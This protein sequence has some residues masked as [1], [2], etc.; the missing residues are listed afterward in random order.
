MI[1]TPKGCLGKPLTHPSF[2]LITGLH[3]VLNKEVEVILDLVRTKVAAAH[4]KIAVLV[5]FILITGFFVSIPV[6][7]HAA[8]CTSPTTTTVG[9]DTVV[10]FTAVESCDWT[11]PAGV[12][13]VWAVVVGGGGASGAGVSNQWWGA[14]GGGGQVTSQTISV[15]SGNTISLSVGAGGATGDGSASSFGSLTANGGKTPTNSTAVGG[16]SGSGMNG[17]SGGAGTTGNGGGGAW[18]A[19][20][21]INPGDGIS[22]SITGATVEYGGGGNGYNGGTTTGTARSGAGSLGVAALA[23]RGGGG[24]LLN[25]A[26]LRGAG[27]SGVVIIRY[28]T[29]GECSPTSA[30]VGTD[31]VLKFT[32]AGSCSWTPPA[33]I[34]TFQILVVGG[35]GGGGSN[36]GGGG[37]GG[38]VVSNT[39]VTITQPTTISVGAGG[40]GGTGTYATTTN[41]GKTGGKSRVVSGSI[42]IQ[43]L[44]GSGGNG[45]MSATNLNPDGSAISTGYTGGGG[46]Y[47]NSP[48]EIAIAGAG[49]NSFIGG[50]G[51]VNGGGGGG[52]GNSTFLVGAGLS[53]FIT[54]AVTSVFSSDSAVNCFQ[55][56]AIK[57][58]PTKSAEPSNTDRFITLG[59][60]FR[61]T[62]APN[63]RFLSLKIISSK[64]AFWLIT[65]DIIF[66]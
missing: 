28:P 10:T 2:T 37:G 40:A 3:W 60:V 38:Q 22:S 61:R 18:K 54:S 42:N 65:C 23:N 7:A 56:A 45:R 8:A 9:T 30:M 57:R 64:V 29:P 16:V 62:K 55:K 32:D 5:S 34:S 15:N 21:G 25:N 12:G 43:A 26:G 47:A 46:A 11:V 13:S 58:A 24:A 33:N 17:G 20:S 48:A 14:G 31:T 27:G 6:T 39:S 44:G 35:G 49:G 41:H 4:S 63:S 1:I 66:V 59:Y 53:S 51:S 19:G 52:G 50:N 36:L